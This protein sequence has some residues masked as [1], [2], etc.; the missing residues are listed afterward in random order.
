MLTGVTLY[1]IAQEALA[2]VIRHAEASEV[3]VSLSIVDGA[4]V[5]EIRDTG[6]G[7]SREQI[8][9]SRSLGLLGMRE[10][11]ELLGGTVSIEARPGEGTIVKATLPLGKEDPNRANTVR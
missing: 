10:R 7:M 5:L 3:E 6:K 9:S 11:A 1:R 2:N 8:A 4:A